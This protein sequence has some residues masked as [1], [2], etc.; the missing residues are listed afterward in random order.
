MKDGLLH[1][2]TSFEMLNDDSFEQLGRDTG[3]PHALRVDHDD[4]PAGADAQARRFATL[5]TCRTEEQLFALEEAGE[6]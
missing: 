6:Q 4:G 1:W 2:P 5:H 3:I